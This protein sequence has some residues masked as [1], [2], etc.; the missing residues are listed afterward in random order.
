MHSA[1]HP[2]TFSALHRIVHCLLLCQQYFDR[3]EKI[4]HEF[5]WPTFVN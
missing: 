4:Y 3:L 1:V 5:F 2:M